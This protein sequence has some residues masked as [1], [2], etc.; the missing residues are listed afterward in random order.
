[1]CFSYIV[2][3]SDDRYVSFIIVILK[4]KLVKMWLLGVCIY[5]SFIWYIVRSGWG[6]IGDRGGKLVGVLWLLWGC[7]SDIGERLGDAISAGST[8]GS[9]GVW[10]I[11][12]E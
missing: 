5:V 10:W 1:M 8:H 7:V 9:F 3:R 11:V 6:G 2:H 12:G 4:G